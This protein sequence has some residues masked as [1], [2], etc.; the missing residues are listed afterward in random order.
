MKRLLTALFCLLMITACA[1]GQSTRDN[2]GKET[3]DPLKTRQTAPVQNRPG[4]AGCYQMGYRWGVCTAENTAG[5]SCN[6]QTDTPIPS[7]CMNRPETRQGIKDGLRA[8]QMRLQ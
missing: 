3:A 4:K 2:A 6:P 5:L 1:S 7:Q 8:T